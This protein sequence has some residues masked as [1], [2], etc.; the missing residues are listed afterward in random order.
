MFISFD[1]GNYRRRGHRKI[2]YKMWDL[3]KAICSLILFFVHGYMFI[4][5]K[6]IFT[7]TVLVID[8]ILFGF[9]FFYNMNRFFYRRVDL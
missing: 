3:T 1:N 4:D 6:A 2:R 5:T 9:L 8:I 7:N